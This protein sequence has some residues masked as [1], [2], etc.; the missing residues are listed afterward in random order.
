MLS[1]QGGAEQVADAV[2]DGEAQCAAD[3]G[4]PT[5]DVAAADAGT[6]RPGQSKGGQDRDDDGASASSVSGASRSSRYIQI[7]RSREG[8]LSAVEVTHHASRLDGATLR[9]L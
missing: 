7:H 5:A 2:G 1:A 4:D 9:E 8:E 6:E 3:Q